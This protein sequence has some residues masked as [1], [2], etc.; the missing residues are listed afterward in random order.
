MIEIPALIAILIAET[1]VLLVGIMVFQEYRRS[2]KKQH[3]RVETNRFIE[4]INKTQ[5]DRLGELCAA[6]IHHNLG[7]NFQECREPLEEIIRC[8]KLLYRQFFDA[9]LNHDSAKIKALDGM[10]RDLTLPYCRLAKQLQEI[11]AAEAVDLTAYQE[12]V[13]A[14]EAS[15]ATS[16]QEIEQVKSHLSLATRSLKDISDEY[17]QMFGS[18]KGITEVQ[19]SMER[20]L[21]IFKRIERRAETIN[22]KAVEPPSPPPPP[23]QVEENIP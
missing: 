7:T 14:L 17:T 10:V 19:Q 18:Y 5:K 11:Q 23:P 6:L 8:E 3:D 20:M 2:R 16:Q 9:F 13:E 21:G 22:A 4:R 1:L 12:K 15:L